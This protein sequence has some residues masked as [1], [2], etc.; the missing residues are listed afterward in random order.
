M[1]ASRRGSIRIGSAKLIVDGTD[2]TICRKAT[3]SLSPGRAKA[4][5][6][7]RLVTLSREVYNAG[8]AERRGAWQLEHRRVSLF[9]QFGEIRE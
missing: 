4:R 9:D 6:L 7:D 1:I 3:F 8:L 2:E 5:V